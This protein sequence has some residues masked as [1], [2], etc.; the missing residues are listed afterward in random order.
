MGKHGVEKVEV[1]SLGK[2]WSG[3]VGIEASEK[4]Q[5]EESALDWREK[6]GSAGLVGGGTEPDL[7]AYVVGDSWGWVEQE[8]PSVVEGVA[9]D[10]PADWLLLLPRLGG[11]GPS[12]PCSPVASV[13]CDAASAAAAA[14]VVGSSQHL[15][16]AG[17]GYGWLLQ[18]QFLA[19]LLVAAAAAS[20]AVVSRCL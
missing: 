13:A 1:A 4:G 3:G 17:T 10:K 18:D 12:V 2:G 15:E 6:E 9:A 8:T 11:A 7:G 14:A 20:F 19:L 16:V 5:A